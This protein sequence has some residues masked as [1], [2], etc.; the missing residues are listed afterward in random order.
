MPDAPQDTRRY[1]HF[2][3]I[4]AVDLAF[5]ADVGCCKARCPGRWPVLM[6]PA[7]ID[8]D[9]KNRR[10]QARKRPIEAVIDSTASI[11][12]TIKD[13]KIR[14][15]SLVGDGWIVKRKGA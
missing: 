12:R 6:N 10:Q 13:G 1:Q 8:L 3:L 11:G 7:T 15:D 5:D 14:H 4:V 9:L 2:V